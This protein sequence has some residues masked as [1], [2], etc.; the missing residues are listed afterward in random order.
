MK[1]VARSNKHARIPRLLVVENGICERAA[2]WSGAE[3][4]DNRQDDVSGHRQAL[5]M[6][7]A[8]AATA[9][10][11]SG[12]IETTENKVR[13]SAS[14]YHYDSG[15]QRELG[16]RDATKYASHTRPDSRPMPCRARLARVKGQGRKGDCSA[17]NAETESLQE[18]PPRQWCTRRVRRCHESGQRQRREAMGIS[19]GGGPMT[20]TPMAP[21]RATIQ[22]PTRML[23]CRAA[24]VQQADLV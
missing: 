18:T 7:E 22:R 4:P 24:S 13:G 15:K 23:R 16:G 20:N 6:C 3:G 19:P 17:K 10:V 14:D 5:T 11:S 1:T 12:P 21:S 2:G 9:I 8:V